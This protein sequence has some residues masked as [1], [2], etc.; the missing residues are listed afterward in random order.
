MNTDSDTKVE[1]VKF[2]LITKDL[3]EFVKKTGKNSDKTGVQLFRNPAELC[4][5]WVSY[6]SD[7]FKPIA[8]LEIPWTENQYGRWLTHPKAKTL[9][10]R[11]RAK[12]IAL[13]KETR[14]LM[15]LVQTLVN[16]ELP[17]KEKKNG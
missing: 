6:E 2:E 12:E 14:K 10:N 4:D 17:I 5:T 11:I 1:P 13:E 3:V 9:L 15:V 8:K 16:R 7:S